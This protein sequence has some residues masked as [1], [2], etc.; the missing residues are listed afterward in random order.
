MVSTF[1]GLEQ[2]ILNFKNVFEDVIYRV[3]F[4]IRTPA[5]S[6]DASS[7]F[8]FQSMGSCK[9]QVE[10]AT[11]WCEFVMSIKA[12]PNIY[13]YYEPEDLRHVQLLLSTDDFEN[14]KRRETVTFLKEKNGILFWCE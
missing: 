3:G 6:S 7:D 13:S 1:E 10:C 5:Q 14:G 9:V 8:S 12:A 2:L 11:F 4:I